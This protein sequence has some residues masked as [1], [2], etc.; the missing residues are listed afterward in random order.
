MKASGIDKIS[1]VG[2][3]GHGEQLTS[4][5]DIAIKRQHGWKALWVHDIEGPIRK[6]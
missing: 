1:K 2:K 3:I 6:R 5:R 4:R